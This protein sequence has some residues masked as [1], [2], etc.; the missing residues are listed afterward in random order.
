MFKWNP[1]RPF[2][3]VDIEATGIKPQTDRIVELSIV[4]IMPEG[5]REV[6]TLRINPCIPIPLEATK[7]HGITDKDV[8]GCPKFPEVAPRVAEILA[9]CDLGGYNVLRYDIPML[10]AEFERANLQFDLSG[11]R[12]VDAQKIFH[13]REPR[14]LTAAVAF[15]CNDLHAN[16]HGAQADAL[17]TIRVLEGQFEKYPDLP[18]GLDELD[19]YCFPRDPGWADRAGRL[20]WVNGE[21]VINFGKKAGQSLRSLV[22]TD[23]GFLKWILKGD[24][25]ED[26][27]EI[28][29]GAMEGRYP[30]PVVSP[31]R[32][33][34]LGR[35]ERE[36]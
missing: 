3:V 27:K 17:A 11:R 13:R 7:I 8:A 9:D 14:D 5:G 2:A 6:H 1:T 31:P 19:Q 30:V 24:F 20:K 10:V 16:A 32:S 15:Y 36:R 34:T 35:A 22:A 23:S 33:D 21:I 29:R 12:I 4:R 26:T 28:V 25:P 18:A